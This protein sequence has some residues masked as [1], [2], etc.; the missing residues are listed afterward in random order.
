M[1][2]VPLPASSKNML[3][4]GCFVVPNSQK[5]ITQVG[6]SS[7]LVAKHLTKRFPG[8]TALD[9]VNL[10][11]K[12][13]E[14]HAIIGENG[15]GKSTF[16]NIIVG[17]LQPDR[18]EIYYFGNR[19]TFRHPSEAL[20]A[21]VAAVYQERTLLPFLTGA[22]NI[23][24]GNEP[25]KFSLIDEGKVYELADKVR[26]DLGV[27]VPLDV[28]IGKLGSGVQQ[29]I[30]II[31]ALY[32]EPRVLLLDEPTAS[33]SEAEV[34]PFLEFIQQVAKERGISII[35]ISHKLQEVFKVAD[36]ISVFTD[37]KN[38][39]TKAKSETSR[40]ECVR[41]MLR[42]KLTESVQVHPS[43]RVDQ[44]VLEVGDC[45]YDGKTHH[46]GFVVFKGEVVGMY[47][48]V[49]AG[50][51][52]CVEAIYGVRPAGKCDIKL[53]GEHI[54]GQNV[55]HMLRKGVVLVPEDKHH[56]LFEDFSLRYNLTI[57]LLERVSSP[58]GLIK[59]NQEKELAVN[60]AEK[61]EV[62][63]ADIEQSVSD[64]SGG[65][66]QK[67][68]ISRSLEM[69]GTKLIIMDEPTKGIDMGVKIEIHSLI[70]KLAEKENKAVLVIS[71]EL[72][73]LLNISDRIYVFY[74][75]E[76]VREFKRD[77]FDEAKIL[78]YALG[79]SRE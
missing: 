74:A 56:A 67:A 19:R 72:P 77:E 4:E 50:R 57:S 61:G 14:V 68:I 51:S 48:L 2:G 30:E 26:R 69:T 22:Q 73:E 63:Y 46:L 37:G 33:L 10:E 52:E 38:V 59:G 12:A 36:T 42:R 54:V 21:G 31:R 47:G 71:S 3:E 5:S 75:G 20:K 41:A 65:N 27:N 23:C 60:I 40:D 18:G 44:A 6:G 79:R 1:Y 17:L 24:L 29:M 78:T 43:A 16:C 11:I 8:V 49:G 58:L 15:A 55:P 13:S 25:A 62:K 28:P 76:I 45:E 39:L 34:D 35:F 32:Y 9:D 53:E 66:K 7:A 64:L 70:R